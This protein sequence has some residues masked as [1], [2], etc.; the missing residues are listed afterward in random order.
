MSHSN[1][2]PSPRRAMATDDNQSSEGFFITGIAFSFEAGVTILKRTSSL[3][4]VAQL[5][6]LPNTFSVPGDVL[7]GFWAVLDREFSLELGVAVVSSVLLYWSGMVLND[8]VDLEVDRRE[9]AGRPLPSGAFSQTSAQWLWRIL[10]AA[11]VLVATFV[12]SVTACTAL[13]LSASIVAYNVV[14]KRTALSPIAM[15]ACRILNVFLGI[16]VAWDQSPNIDFAAAG[17]LACLNGVY[18]VGITTMAKGEV[19]SEARS[20]L[21]LGGILGLIGLLGHA[22]VWIILGAANVVAATILG[23][24]GVFWGTRSFRAWRVGSSTSIMAAVKTGILGLI[25]LDAASIAALHDPMVGGGLLLL[26]IPALWLGRWLYT[27]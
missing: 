26:L 1:E 17:W 6:R 23:I 18:I 2:G 12:G 16:G 14:L 7:L 21:A 11:G 22:I 20:P 3:M 5:V 8:V 15:G 27:T 24:A 19:E 4:A 10:M 9:R 13:A 25:A